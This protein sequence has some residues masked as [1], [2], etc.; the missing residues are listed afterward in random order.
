MP[1]RDPLTQDYE[2]PIQQETDANLEAEQDLMDRLNSESRRNIKTCMEWEKQILDSSALTMLTSQA[3]YQHY[4]TPTLP[5]PLLKLEY[6]LL[7]K[8]LLPNCPTN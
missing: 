8:K 6:E 7:K 4:H 1:P 5:Y 3:I 2:E